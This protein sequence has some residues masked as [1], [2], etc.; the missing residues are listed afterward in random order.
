MSNLK[1]SFAISNVQ[2]NI[3]TSKYS[4]EQKFGD[5]YMTSFSDDFLISK[6]EKEF[7]ISMDNGILSKDYNSLKQNYI[8][9]TDCSIKVKGSDMNTQT[10]YYVYL[11]NE[12]IFV[13]FNDLFLTQ[14][15]LKSLG[16]SLKYSNELLGEELTFFENVQ[17]LYY[18]QEINI[19]QNKES[20]YFELKRFSDILDIKTENYTISEAKSNFY[21]ALYRS[22]KELTEGY[23]E[24][25]VSL[26]GGI[27]SGTIVYILNQL[28]KKIHAYSLGTDWDNE[29]N[30][31][32]ET[33]DYLGIKLHRIHLNK[34]EILSEIPHV[35]RNFG[36]I[37]NTSIEVALVGFCLYKK[38][39]SKGHKNMTFVTGYGSDLMNAGIYK[40]FSEYNE[41]SL[42]II[43]RLER[44]RVSNEFS[45]FPNHNMGI[46][47]I[48]PFWHTNVIKEAL[49]I[50]SYF[51]VAHGKDKFYFR[52][53]MST[54]LPTSIA[55]RTKKGAH[56]GTGLAEYLKNTLEETYFE[57]TSRKIRYEDILKELH[58][59][60][61]VE[62]NYPTNLE[63]LII[64]RQKNRNSLNI[65]TIT[66]N[67]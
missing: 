40:K 59:E 14:N 22:I 31:A 39:L 9:M 61:F 57:I 20:L 35:I 55:W 42:D 46:K 10:I 50:P 5:F 2:L 16:L 23:E 67:N 15:I 38:L 53:L 24:V 33:A 51:K 12:N 36:F 37:D 62:G 1:R 47:V 3:S 7:Y 52:D 6:D 11:K 13:V 58:Y 41:L 49:R 28:N 8:H 54:K 66:S 56:Q 19:V 64:S 18:G 44:T 30:E 60:I 21:N 25:Y 45:D 27:D 26:S 43:N 34:E 29:Y 17:R 32:Q 65:S 48:H 4:S 63:N